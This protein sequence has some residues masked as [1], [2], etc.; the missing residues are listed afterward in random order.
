[1]RKNAE[2]GKFIVIEGLD[3]SGQTTQVNR[4][5]EF[6]EAK[7]FQVVTTKEPTPD[8]KAGK[9]IRQIL[10][11]KVKLDFKELQV[12]FAEDRR[13][14]LESL[15]EPAL[16]EGKVVIS[17]RYFF[18]SFAYGSASGVDLEWLIDL[19]SG[20][21]LP[22]LT[23]M[24]KVA[25]RICLERIDNRKTERTLFEEEERLANVW[26]TFEKMPVRFENVFVI[27]GELQPKEVT[28][29]ILTLVRLKLDIKN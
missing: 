22:D 1:M 16:K 3:G 9:E 15:V 2:T 12:L 23:F 5:R 19:N 27:N 25:P 21:L 13:E 4:L 20:F 17:D 18:S 11:K 29:E 24:L 7:G 26:K 10:D 6:L 28:D 8:S 14:H